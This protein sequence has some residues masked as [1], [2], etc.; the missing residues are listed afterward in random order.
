MVLYLYC[1]CFVP[2]LCPYSSSRRCDI[3]NLCGELG[4]AL[5]LPSWNWSPPVWWWAISRPFKGLPGYRF[6][7][8]TGIQEFEGLRP[9]K[10]S[11]SVG[12]CWNTALAVTRAAAQQHRVRWSETKSNCPNSSAKWPHSVGQQMLQQYQ[13]FR[14]L[15]CIPRLAAKSSNHLPPPP[16]GHHSRHFSQHQGLWGVVSCT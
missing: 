7:P 11:A 8:T 4:I 1:K 15:Q 5:T 10:F 3:R 9:G 12:C 16:M 6:A 14:R 2:G 13:L